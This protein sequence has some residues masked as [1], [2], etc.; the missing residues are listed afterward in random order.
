MHSLTPF[1]WITMG[2]TRSDGIVLFVYIINM[3]ARSRMVGVNVWNRCRRSAECDVVYC[4][5][6]TF[7]IILRQKIINEMVMV[8][9]L[10]TP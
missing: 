3:T 9:C 5:T 6:K 2:T 8:Q 10:G 7:K 4:P 1:I